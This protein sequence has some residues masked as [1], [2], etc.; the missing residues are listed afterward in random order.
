MKDERFMLDNARGLTAGIVDMI[1]LCVKV[2]D[3]C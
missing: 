3:F 2:D 1:T